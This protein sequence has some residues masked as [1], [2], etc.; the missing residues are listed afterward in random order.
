MT[1]QRS[2]AEIVRQSLKTALQ[3]RWTK[4]V[5]TSGCSA[6]DKDVEL[7]RIV[8]SVTS[9]SLRNFDHGSFAFAVLRLAQPVHEFP[10]GGKR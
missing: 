9:F 10:I 5:V 2:Q 8:I 4:V 1:D 6:N 3:T 7:N